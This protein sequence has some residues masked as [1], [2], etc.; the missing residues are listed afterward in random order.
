[1][2]REARVSSLARSSAVPARLRKQPPPRIKASI[3]VSHKIGEHDRP[4]RLALRNPAAK[5]RAVNLNA[6]IHRIDTLH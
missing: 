4:S 3:F 2:T 5:Y 6:V 1:M